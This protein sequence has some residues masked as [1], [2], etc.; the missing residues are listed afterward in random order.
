MDSSAVRSFCRVGA[1]ECLGI[2]VCPQSTIGQ[3]EIQKFHAR[4]REHDVAGLQIPMNDPSP[5]RLVQPVRDLNPI[6]QG[7]LELQ[8]SF[9]EP[10]GQRV[11]L[12]VLHHDE[13]DTVLLTHIVEGADVR[14]V[15]LR[16]RLGFAIEAGFALGAFGEVLGEDFDRHRPVEARVLGFVDLAHAPGSDGRDDLV[17][18]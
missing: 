7:L 17:G 4:L 6:L 13:V 2:V 9:L 15:Q 12:D 18:A 14:V 8:R 10:F 1:S 16:D 11:A 5:V 3:A